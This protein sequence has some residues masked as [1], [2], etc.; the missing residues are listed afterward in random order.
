MTPDESVTKTTDVRFWRQLQ[1]ELK[2]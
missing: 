1:S 2:R